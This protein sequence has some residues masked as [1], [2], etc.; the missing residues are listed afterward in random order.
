MSATLTFPRYFRQL[1]LVGQEGPNGHLLGLRLCGRWWGKSLAEG[2]K[3]PRHPVAGHMS[4]CSRIWR[5]NTRGSG[6]PMIAVEESQET[7]QWYWCALLTQSRVWGRK[8]GRKNSRHLGR[9][10]GV[11]QKGRIG[12]GCREERGLPIKGEVEKLVEG[13]SAIGAARSWSG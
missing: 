8:K 11:D 10:P 2:P 1:T 12:P 5:T 9:G 7:R 6:L 4:S 3:S 13:K